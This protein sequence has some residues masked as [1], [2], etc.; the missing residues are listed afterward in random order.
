[1]QP[2][3]AANAKADFPLDDLQSGRMDLAC[4]AVSA[5]M[6][7]S[8]GV[9][10]DVDVVLLLGEEEVLKE[11][12][13]GAVTITECEELGKTGKEGKDFTTFV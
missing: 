8:S 1:M 13:A 12:T 11:D 4:R 3:R 10:R 5:A 7:F 9:R 2:C 6:F